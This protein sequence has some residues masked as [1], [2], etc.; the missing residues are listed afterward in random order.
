[1]T[2]DFERGN[3]AESAITGL[4]HRYAELMDAGDFVAAAALFRRARLVVDRGGE[5]ALDAGTM[6][7]IWTRDVIVYPDGTPRTKHVTTNL[8]VHVDDAAGSATCRSYY[9]VFQ[10]T[11]EFPLQPILC[12]RY[13]DRFEHVDGA[14]HFTERDYSMLDLVGDTSRHLRTP[15]R[16][17]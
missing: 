4:V 2:E 12:G 8:N 1:V 6:L 7:A 11:D 9:T 15:L 5:L 16:R 14:W 3:S 17:A 10:Q 13:H